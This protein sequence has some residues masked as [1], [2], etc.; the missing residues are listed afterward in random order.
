MTSKHY[1]FWLITLCVFF[2][3]YIQ[4]L[5]QHGLFFDGLIYSTLANNL[6]QGIGTIY[7]P[8]ISKFYFSS[9]HEHPTLGI[10]LESLYFRLFGNAYYVERL[11]SLSV[12]SV[13]L[14]LIYKFWSILNLKMEHKAFAWLPVLYFI[15]LPLVVWSYTQNM[16]EVT[17]TMF[18]F[19]SVFLI[20]VGIT[21]K[22]K[23]KQFVY[24]LFAAVFIVAG[25]LTKGPVGLFPL[26]SILLYYIT[27]KSISFKKA[28][29][30]NLILLLFVMII[31]I[32]LL[33]NENLYHSLKIYMNQQVI[34]SLNGERDSV[35]NRYILLKDLVINILPLGIMTLIVYLR[36]RKRIKQKVNNKNIIMFFIATGFSA[37]L[38][39]MIS[40]KQYAFYLVP[41]LIY[42]SLAFAILSFP[43]MKY[44]LNIIQN[45]KR[46]IQFSSILLAISIVYVGMTIGQYSRDKKLLE[47]ISSVAQYI[48]PDKIIKVERAMRKDVLL[49]A[50]FA[51]YYNIE[52]DSRNEYL[53]YLKYK[54]KK[55]SINQKSIPVE[56]ESFNLYVTNRNIK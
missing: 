28:V 30:L 47:D 33:Q 51:R 29:V 50:Y 40:T 7:E 11:Y 42:F 6:A 20:Y 1:I 12:L 35:S 37:S 21:I 15:S 5:V 49:N 8:R 36:G 9:F 14:Y 22:D 56:I 3:F 39:I 23:R 19:L 13:V 45:T 41:S 18:S 27:V 4:K 26:V 54:N 38:P 16:L 24:M 10:Y 52:L 53:Y 44:L 55:R 32:I 17:L 46:Y 34:A 31:F 43:Y 2:L 48:Y 25:F